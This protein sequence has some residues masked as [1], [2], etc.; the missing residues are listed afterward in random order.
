M[1]SAVLALFWVAGFFYCNG[2][3]ADE[4]HVDTK[5]DSFLGTSRTFALLK[6][7]TNDGIFQ[8]LIRCRGGQLAVFIAR[9]DSARFE[10][11]EAD[12]DFRFD[13]HD[14]IS[15]SW[16]RS[17]DGEA[18]FFRYSGL[19]FDKQWQ[20]LQPGGAVDKIFLSTQGMEHNEWFIWQIAR[21]SVFRV[22]IV[23]NETYRVQFNTTGARDASNQVLKACKLTTIPDLAA[24]AAKRAADE[25][26]AESQRREEEEQRQAALAADKARDVFEST[27]RPNADR[28]KQFKFLRQGQGFDLSLR[29]SECLEF[30]LVTDGILSD[31]KIL[32]RFDVSSNTNF[33]RHEMIKFGDYFILEGPNNPASAL[34]VGAVRNVMIL[35]T[36]V[37]QKT[38]KGC[39]PLKYNDIGPNK[40]P[41]VR[42]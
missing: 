40:T 31:G 22:Q 11:T 4:W 34:A 21:S 32:V 12:V 41:T 13:E 23:D 16:S 28:W 19:L 42:M 25:A 17:T 9:S 15:S 37:W 26:R 39:E 30:I 8:L 38:G 14:A 5:V 24:L 33:K 1:K 10:N 6:S 3:M 35:Q 27:K 36:R 29:A 2:A 7:A 18:L 20:D